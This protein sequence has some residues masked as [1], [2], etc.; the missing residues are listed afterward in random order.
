MLRFRHPSKFDQGK[1]GQRQQDLERSNEYQGTR[2]R[3]HFFQTR[4]ERP[5]VTG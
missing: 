3:D 2:Q 5:G 4:N 1:F